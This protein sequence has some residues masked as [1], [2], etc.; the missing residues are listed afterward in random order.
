VA[1]REFE[2]GG[3]ASIGTDS[4]DVIVPDLSRSGGARAS[5]NGGKVSIGTDSGGGLFHGSVWRS[6]CGRKRDT[7]GGMLL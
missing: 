1:E 6:G 4:G 2:I 7:G 3:K 5:P